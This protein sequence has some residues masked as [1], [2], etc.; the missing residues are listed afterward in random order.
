KTSMQL[1]TFVVKAQFARRDI[2]EMRRIACHQVPLLGRGN[3]VEIIGL[4]H[5]DTLCQ[6]VLR[7]RTTAC[8]NRLRIDVGETQ[9]IAKSVAK[10]SK[11]DKPRPRAPLKRPRLARHSEIMG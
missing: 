11:A 6:S 7:N 4:I 10:K 3:A 8:L 1:P 5:R 2:D 9:S